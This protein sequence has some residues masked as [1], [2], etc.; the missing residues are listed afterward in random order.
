MGCLPLE[1]SANG[2]MEYGV[3]MVHKLQLAVPTY[4]I[5]IPGTEFSLPLDFC[6]IFLLMCWETANEGSQVLLF[7]KPTNADVHI[8]AWFSSTVAGFLEVN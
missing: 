8:L 3:G 5:P 2:Y 1:T 7:L 6:S 4:L